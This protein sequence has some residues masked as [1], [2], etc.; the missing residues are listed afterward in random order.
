M[1]AGT[2]AAARR[3]WAVKPYISLL[4]SNAVI[5]QAASARSIA[6]FQPRKSR[7]DRI[8]ANPPIVGSADCRLPTA[9][10]RILSAQ[11]HV[12][13]ALGQLLAEAAL[14]ELGHHRPLELVALVEEGEAEPEPDIAEDL[15]VLGPGHHRARA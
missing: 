2:E 8:A 12:G 5:R 3:I 11:R 1:F 4:G 9:D 14:V 10:C 15:G 7:S 13:G 6:S